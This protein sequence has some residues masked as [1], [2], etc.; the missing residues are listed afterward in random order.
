MSNDILSKIEKLLALAAN[1]S[2]ENEAAAAMAKA[3]ALMT[4]HG[5]SQSQ[6]H[7]TEL[8]IADQSGMHETATDWEYLAY[9]A[10]ARLYGCATIQYDKNQFTVVG[11]EEHIDA[12]VMTGKWLGE[13]IQALYKKD[14]PK[15]LGQNERANFRRT[16]KYSCAVRVY[17][18]AGEAIIQQIKQGT[19]GSTALVV[20]NHFDTLNEENTRKLDQIGVRS[21]PKQIRK[22]GL[23]T[24]MGRAAGNQV[25][26]RRE[27]T[28]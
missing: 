1:N 25:K 23:G 6:L 13:Q 22:A 11:R 27:L 15:G 9:R 28:S 12:T 14:L 8:R 5:I 19:S 20:S 7:T 4:D 2:N 18:R 16:Y 17:E 26:L 10:A 21:L 24:A 3:S